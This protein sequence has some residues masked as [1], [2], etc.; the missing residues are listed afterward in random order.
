MSLAIF[1][2]ARRQAERTIRGG[3]GQGALRYVGKTFNPSGII[4]AYEGL[5]ALSGHP[6]SLA[7]GA[8]GAGAK[9][10]STALTNAN[11]RNL[12]A[13]ILRGGTAAPPKPP[14]NLSPL[15]RALAAYA[16]AARR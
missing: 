7:A 11:A 13:T 16:P 3:P 1:R 4:G 6:A 15:A 14:V 2:N 9:A 12:M 8:I 10:A 5:D